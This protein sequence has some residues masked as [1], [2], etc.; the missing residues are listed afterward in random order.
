MA[1]TLDH[2]QLGPLDFLE[3]REAAWVHI[4]AGVLVPM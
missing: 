2:R 4:G 3:L 1:P